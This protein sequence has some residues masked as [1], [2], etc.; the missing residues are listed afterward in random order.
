LKVSIKNV[1]V[2]YDAKYDIGTG[3]NISSWK[4]RKIGEVAFSI[5]KLLAPEF[6]YKNDKEIRIRFAEFYQTDVEKSE[7]TFNETLSE[8]Y[9]KVFFEPEYKYTLGDSYLKRLLNITGSS[10]K[11]VKGFWSFDFDE[12]EN[13]IYDSS[14]KNKDASLYGFTRLLYNFDE[15][16]DNTFYNAY[17]DDL[18]LYMNFNSGNTHDSS[19]SGYTVDLINETDCNVDGFRQKGCVF[20]GNRDY[21]EITNVDDFHVTKEDV[22]FTAW[23]NVSNTPSTIISKCDSNVL[24][25]SRCEKNSSYIFYVSLNN[26]LVFS[27]EIALPLSSKLNTNALF[28]LT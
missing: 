18:S 11:D 28:K 19:K 12:Q 1:K 6:Y 17:Y 16:E 27:F 23:I 8:M 24:S 20:D 21:L 9:S 25:S 26:A 13:E 4:F 10:Y 3:D 14:R 22:S 2:L 7:I 15:G 5:D